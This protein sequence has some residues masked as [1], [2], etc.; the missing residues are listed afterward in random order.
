MDWDPQE[1]AW[2]PEPSQRLLRFACTRMVH[3]YKPVLTGILLER[4]PSLRVPLAEVQ[5]QF[6]AF[7]QAR[8]QQGLPIERRQTAILRNGAVEA[9][10]ARIV[11]GKILWGVFRVQGF[12]HLC[13]G[14]LI[15]QPASAWYGLASEPARTKAMAA[16]RRALSDFYER[17]ELEGEAVYG[18][19]KRNGAADAH[20]MVFLVPDPDD[21]DDMFILPED[22]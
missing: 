17:I 11:A 15:L 8:E 13:G 14:E 20:E 6:V 21:S 18:R 9:S 16:L 12:A 22:Y 3:S 1:F 19:T 2:L 7:Y 10:A 4:L 5:D